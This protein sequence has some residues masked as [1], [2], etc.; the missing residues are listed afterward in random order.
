MRNIYLNSLKNAI[1]NFKE[2]VKFKNNF[3][4][5][6]ITHLITFIGLSKVREY[7]NSNI[8]NSCNIFCNLKKLIVLCTKESLEN[9]LNLK[10]YKINKSIEVE[11]II[12]EN[13]ISYNNLYI[14]LLELIENFEFSSIFFDATQGMKS[15]T[16]N[17]YKLSIELGIKS[18]TWSTRHYEKEDNNLFRDVTNLKI[19][20]LDNPKNENYNF[21]KTINEFIEKYE[22]EIVYKLYESI[23]DIHKSKLFKLLSYIFHENS[24]EYKTFQKEIINFSEEYHKFSNQVKRESKELYNIL[25]FFLNPADS[26]ISIV[27]FQDIIDTLINDSVSEDEIEYLYNYL[28]IPFVLK[29]FQNLSIKKLIFSKNLSLAFSKKN[30]N[31]ETD[32]EN[33]FFNIINN[34]YK[35]RGVEIFK[36]NLNFINILKEPINN[37][38]NITIKNIK[39]YGL[40]LPFKNKLIIEKFFSN[41]LKSKVL[42]SLLTSKD[43]QIYINDILNIMETLKIKNISKGFT[44]LEANFLKLNK[45]LNMIFIREKLPYFNIIKYIPNKE[46]RLKKDKNIIIADYQ[47][48]KIY[49]KLK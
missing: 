37:K 49:I 8:E 4:I 21:F 16:I 12:I 39:I 31:Y 3:N 27:N 42:K 18:L 15:I 26:D 38:L 25:S 44:D 17:F 11:I 24:I 30:I 10:K 2:E 36:S 40:N 7:E 28:I 20:F 32:E 46:T 1:L 43:N 14:L 33:Y 35:T 13:E 19:D 29:K 48:P 22:F 34:F 41:D 23:N 6:D 5:K 9:A 45:E 47:L